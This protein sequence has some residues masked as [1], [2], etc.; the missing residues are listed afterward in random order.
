MIACVLLTFDFFFSVF[1]MVDNVAGLPAMG[2]GDQEQRSP[3]PG[4][5]MSCHLRRFRCNDG[6]SLCEHPRA[7][8]RLPLSANRP[9]GDGGPCRRAQRL[10]TSGAAPVAVVSRDVVIEVSFF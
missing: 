4:H 7:G 1:I 5:P 3:L 8:G 2:S 9:L 10:E 6:P